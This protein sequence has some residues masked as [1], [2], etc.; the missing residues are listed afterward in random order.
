[1]SQNISLTQLIKRIP[2]A[3]LHLHIEWTFEP[4][5]MFK[6]A[7]RNKIA[8]KYPSVAALKKA[9]NFGNLQD[10]L[11]IYYQGASVLMKEK[12]FYDLTWEYLKKAHK[13]N[14]IHTEIFFDPQ[15]H[16]DRWIQFKT[17]ITW[18]H[19]ALVDAK[20][21][22][23]MTSRLIMCFLRHLDEKAAMKTLQQA[24]PYKKWITAVGLDSSEIGHPPHD[25]KNVFAQARKQW[26]L[27]VAHAGEEGPA[28]YIREAVKL[29]K[30]SR[31]DHGNRCLD[32]KKLIQDLVKKQIPLTVCPL[33][34]SKLQVVK[35]MYKHPLKKMLNLWLLVS[36]NSDDP[37]Y[38]G[39]YV[40]DNYLAMEK[41]LKFSREEIVQLASNSFISSFLS[42]KEK[43]KIVN[44]MKKYN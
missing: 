27:T 28:A 44:Q 23:G 18:I 31:I 6:I 22:W 34:N 1:M 26:Y 7:K 30:V 33:S 5:L 21:K 39:G 37:A 15:T 41:A 9:Y 8:I 3:E 32:D 38:F 10:F 12:D 16:T 25:F 36:V 13:D 42:Q 35:D 40:V 11:D 29:L 20:K 14:V 24:L 43:N 4:E 17:V 19:Q 2:K